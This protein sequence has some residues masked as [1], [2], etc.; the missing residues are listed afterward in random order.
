MRTTTVGGAYSA[1]GTKTKKRTNQQLL[2]GNYKGGG[3]CG[4][5]RTWIGGK[6]RRCV[7][8]V[9]LKK[10]E[11]TWGEGRKKGRWHAP[12]T[13]GKTGNKT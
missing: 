5:N 11:Q 13:G 8:S 10:K 2:R 12:R 9:K 3:R 1:E 4:R 7:N 6:V